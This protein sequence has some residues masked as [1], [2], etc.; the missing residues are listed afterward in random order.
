MASWLQLSRIA[1][2]RARLGGAWDGR[3]SLGRQRAGSVG[4]RSRCGIAR[5][6]NMPALPDRRD[7]ATG[8]PGPDCRSA[9]SGIASTRNP[10][11]GHPGPEAAAGRPRSRQG[12]VRAPCN[13]LEVFGRNSHVTLGSGLNRRPKRPC[14]NARRAR[15]VGRRS[16]GV[17]RSATAR[18]DSSRRRRLE[19]G[20]HFAGADGGDEDAILES[21]DAMQACSEEALDRVGPP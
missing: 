10:T 16:V 4:A 18:A 20:V 21:C 11:P 17:E 1:A 9:A 12:G 8:R 3:A 19:L 14:G 2:R 13:H 6:V 15:S 7:R 5:E